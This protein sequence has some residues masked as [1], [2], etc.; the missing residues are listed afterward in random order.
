MK[1]LRSPFFKDLWLECPR[2]P[3]ANAVQ[4]TLSA[5]TTRGL[6]PQALAQQANSSHFQEPVSSHADVVPIWRKKVSAVV[7]GWE[8]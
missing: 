2:R 6:D 8:S 7:A 3:N 5:V 4:L 1:R